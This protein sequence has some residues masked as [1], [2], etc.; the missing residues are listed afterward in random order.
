MAHVIQALNGA[1]SI[2]PNAVSGHDG[3]RE[4]RTD[5]HALLDGTTG[6]VYRAP[7]LRRGTLVLVFVDEVA[8]FA[9]AD[10]LAARTPFR[11]TTDRPARLSMKFAVSGGSVTVDRDPEVAYVWYVQAPFAE[12]SP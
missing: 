2:V 5:V 6:T 11:Y 4:A 7:G 12:V 10:L 3:A 8:A 9:A 1:G